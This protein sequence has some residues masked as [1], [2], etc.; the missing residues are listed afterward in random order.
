MR[1][2]MSQLSYYGYDVYNTEHVKKIR[3]PQQTWKDGAPQLGASGNV[4]KSGLVKE[5]DH[6]SG[7]GMILSDDGVEY[8]FNFTAIPGEGYRTERAGQKINFEVVDTETGQVAFNIQ[9][10]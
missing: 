4:V 5:F 1:S 6:N 7:N 8:F 10:V 9:S 2:I 3:V